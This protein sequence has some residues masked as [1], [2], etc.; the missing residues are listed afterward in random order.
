MMLKSGLEFFIF[1]REHSCSGSL[2]FVVGVV[3]GGQTLVFCG[4]I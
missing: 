4:L 1:D 3:V 2:T